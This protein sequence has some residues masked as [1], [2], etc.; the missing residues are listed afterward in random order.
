ALTIECDAPGKF[1]LP[2]RILAG[3]NRRHLEAADDAAAE[4]R[5]EHE[6]RQLLGVADGDVQVLVLE[7]Q[8]GAEVRAL[9]RRRTRFAALR[10]AGGNEWLYRC[11]DSILIRSRRPNSHAF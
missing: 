10:A 5:L 11:H 4:Q 9:E 8:A 1:D 6:A 7:Q 2:L 3:R